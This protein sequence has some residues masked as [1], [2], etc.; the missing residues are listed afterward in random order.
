MNS[1]LVVDD[2]PANLHLLTSLLSDSGYDVRAVQDAIF[3]LKSIQSTQP[4]LILLDIRMPGMDGYEVCERLKADER[5]RDIPVIFL[6]ALSDMPDKLKGFQVGGVDY[7]TKPFQAEE[8]L[9][10]VK[11]HLNLYHL[12]KQLEEANTRLQSKNHEL[13]SFAFIVSH[14]LKAPLRDLG[15]LVRWLEED[16][17][18]AFDE[19]GQE[20]ANMALERIGRMD[21]SI[22]RI[23]RYSRAGYIDRSKEQIDLH[24]LVNDVLSM[25]HPPDQ[26]QVLIES[27]LP[28]I[29][30]E[31]TSLQQI[32]QNL[33]ENAIRYMDKVDGKIWIRA[34]QDKR[35]W[36]MS[37][38]DNGPGI[39]E[40]YHEKIFDIFQTA[41]AR[42]DGESSGVGLAIV[43]K[44]V[45]H[46]G[47]K[48]WLESSPGKG[49]EFF[50]T[51]PEA[52]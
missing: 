25:L 7:I 10:R 5:T 43:K 38:A 39:E 35:S 6:S 8:V 2:K 1:I 18:H 45:E 49:S 12:H 19:R 3:A 11:A 33:L 36:I 32:F 41:K 37:V 16:Y 42:D 21:R 26:I 28:C 29:V 51:L 4:D 27:K 23:L 15:N 44:I 20:M 30:G 24:V 48:I 50:F 52:D 14:D 17:A 9:S 22:N 13:K 31:K 46:Y 40:R 34:V 47:G